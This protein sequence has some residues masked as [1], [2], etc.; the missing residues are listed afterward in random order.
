MSNPQKKENKESLCDVCHMLTGEEVV[1]SPD[2]FYLNVGAAVEG[3]LCPKCRRERICL[4]CHG[5]KTSVAF[6]K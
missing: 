2:M 1:I 4:E 6:L 3:H 5:G